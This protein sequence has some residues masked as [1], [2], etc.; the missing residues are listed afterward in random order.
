VFE[1]YLITDGSQPAAIEQAVAEA[2]V[3][4]QPGRVTVQLRAKQLASRELLALAW[5]LRDLT[6]AHQAQLIIN[7]RVDI[8]RITAADGVHLPEQGLPV[9]AARA[10][11]GE[12]GLIGV[13]CHDLQGL[14]RAHALGA[15]FATLSPVFATRDKGPALG[16]AR[17]AE[18]TQK[19]Q[20]P[21]YALGGV[22][23]EHAAPL[24]AAGAAGLALIS[25]V[26]AAGDRAAALQSCL[27]S[28][29]SAA[30]QSKA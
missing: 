7:D 17:F 16:V 15:D 14:E 26:F 20:L 9:D 10:L 21:V 23:A 4:S 27:A 6:R 3:G 5:A 30:A 24:R 2:L 28:W 11:L 29:Q 13:S 12:A 1:L 18:W 19:V 8:A 25:A 22:K